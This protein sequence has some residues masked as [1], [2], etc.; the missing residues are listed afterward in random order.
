M[1]YRILFV[2]CDEV[3]KGG[4]EYGG[5]ISKKLYYLNSCRL[6]VIY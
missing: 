2:Y 1:F 5:V 3:C 6:C 4:N